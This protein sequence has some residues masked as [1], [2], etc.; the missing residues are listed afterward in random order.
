MKIRI[1]NHF[2]Q[3]HSTTNFN[4]QDNNE[5][6]V[7]AN[8]T[9]DN[10]TTNNNINTRSTGQ[11]TSING[12]LHN[13]QPETNNSAAQCDS[14]TSFWFDRLDYSSSLN[15]QQNRVTGMEDTQTLNQPT[16]QSQQLSTT[17]PQ[18]V[19]FYTPYVEALPKMNLQKFNGDPSK[20]AD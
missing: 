12:T 1:Q 19:P 6:T 16:V 17:F 13:E 14:L 10:S 20:W 5:T 3:E 11:Q 4:T 9:I 8:L 2:L 7:A 15:D 18:P